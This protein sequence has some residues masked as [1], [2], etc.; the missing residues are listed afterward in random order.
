STEAAAIACVS[1]RP[2]LSDAVVILTGATGGIGHAIARMLAAAGA[3]LAVTDLAEQ[4]VAELAADVDALGEAV[5][6]ASWDG[7]GGFCT[8]VEA[9]LGPV[10][11][12]VNCAGLWAPAPY[13]EV[14]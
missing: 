5:D 2:L 14:D 10:D 11:G 7:F 6:A 4:P 9:E 8:R 1:G 13:D 12:L 3:R